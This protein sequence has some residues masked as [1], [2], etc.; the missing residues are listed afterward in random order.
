MKRSAF[1]K[2]IS[3]EVFRCDPETTNSEELMKHHEPVK[4]FYA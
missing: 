3:D 4:R 1:S 2:R